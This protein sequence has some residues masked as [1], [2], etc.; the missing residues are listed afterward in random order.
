VAIYIPTVRY[1]QY[2]DR[3]GIFKKCR[4]GCTISIVIVTP[5]FGGPGNGSGR[6]IFA[7]IWCRV[8]HYNQGNVMR[9]SQV[10]RCKLNKFM[11]FSLRPPRRMPQATLQRKGSRVSAA[12]VDC[13][14]EGSACGTTIATTLKPSSSGGVARVSTRGRGRS[15]ARHASAACE[16]A[17]VATQLLY[18]GRR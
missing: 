17:E 8:W 5:D 14:S 15:R 7:F 12:A 11:L 2:T 1:D 4:F 18:I 6:H 10:Q 9:L 13:A 16:R 3:K